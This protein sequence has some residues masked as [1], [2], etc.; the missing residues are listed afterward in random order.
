MK[1]CNKCGLHKDLIHFYKNCGSKDGLKSICKQC[2][3][4][5]VKEARKKDPERFKNYFKSSYKRNKETINKK[6]RERFKNNPKLKKQNRL[7]PYNLTEEE[8]DILMNVSNYKCNICNLSR[9]DHKLN[10]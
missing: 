5:G 7:R 6:N 8:F 1:K 4:N 2:V 3:E 9:E 10:I